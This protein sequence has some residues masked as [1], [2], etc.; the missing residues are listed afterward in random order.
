MVQELEL[1]EVIVVV[2]VVEVVEEDELDRECGD[3]GVEGECEGEGDREVCVVEAV[4]TTEAE[5]LL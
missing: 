3:V 2:E 1:V 4:A 5:E